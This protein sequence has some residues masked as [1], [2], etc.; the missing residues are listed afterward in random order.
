MKKNLSKPGKVKIKS[1]LV[2]GSLDMGR[3]K[4]QK[5]KKPTNNLICLQKR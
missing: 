1:S 5:P 3:A 4:S 2:I